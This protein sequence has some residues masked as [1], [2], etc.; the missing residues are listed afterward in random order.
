M[1]SEATMYEAL[2]DLDD[3]KK[4]KKKKRRRHRGKKKPKT[5]APVASVPA[6][7]ADPAPAPKPVVKRKAR[8]PAPKPVSAP[9]A[10][11]AP[12]PAAAAPA[13][14][15]RDPLFHT[16]ETV[17]NMPKIEETISAFIKFL[18][19]D[20]RHLK[21]FFESNALKLLVTN[22]LNSRP[23]IHID[24]KLQHLFT[25]CL[26]AGD[27]NGA[28]AAHLVTHKLRRIIEA[29]NGVTSAQHK[30]NTDAMAHWIAKT[31]AQQKPLLR[32]GKTVEQELQKL[33]KQTAERSQA[34]AAAEKKLQKSEGSIRSRFGF[35]DAKHDL[36]KCL[37]RKAELVSVESGASQAKGTAS[38]ALVACPFYKQLTRPQTGFSPKKEQEMAELEATMKEMHRQRMARI[39]PLEDKVRALQADVDELTRRKEQLRVQLAQTEDLLEKKGEQLL[40]EDELK[41][42]IDAEFAAKLQGMSASHREVSTIVQEAV[43]RKQLVKELHE[44]GTD[45]DGL[46][47]AAHHT[48]ASSHSHERHE[49]RRS[50]LGSCRPYLVSEKACVDFLTRRS[51]RSVKSLASFRKELDQLEKGNM[52]AGMPETTQDLR[53][54]I[55]ALETQ[56][57]GDREVTKKLVSDASRVFDAVRSHSCAA[58][59]SASEC[60]SMHALVGLFRALN[61]GNDWSPP[62][63]AE[64]VSGETEVMDAQ[65]LRLLTAEPPAPT[66]ATTVQKKQPPAQRR[67]RPV[68]RAPAPA[69]KPSKPITFSWASKKKAPSKPQTSLAEILAAENAKKKADE[70][71]KR[72]DDSDS[73]DEEDEEDDEGDEE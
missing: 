43:K 60:G 15:G 55:T 36:V 16:L 70:R 3:I 56:L 24:S 7:V 8:T 38:A 1:P 66:A 6:P 17:S 4:T 26:G 19:L 50:F 35:R 48:V 37:M 73:E 29:L 5:A 21:A 68:A 65:L 10:V 30:S 54:K 67:A 14:S 32:S 11:P 41:V 27:G 42:K 57:G 72:G 53:K 62:P 49:A 46:A 22:L 58:D 63:S 20:P 45:L 59:L 34:S 13:T 71:A 64:A 31:I 40:Y 69:L 44:L 9:A 2:A 51:E 12:A 61:I 23:P 47:T 33:D 39:Q 52:A 18:P 28:G 25:L